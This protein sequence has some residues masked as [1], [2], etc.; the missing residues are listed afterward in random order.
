MRARYRV[1]PR[2]SFSLMQSRGQDTKY[3]LCGSRA[4][5]PMPSMRSLPAP[6][7]FILCRYSEDGIFMFGR[8]NFNRA[9]VM[10]L[11]CVRELAEH[12]EANDPVRAPP[13][14]IEVRARPPNSTKQRAAGA[15]PVRVW[16]TRA[17]VQPPSDPDK[18]SRGPDADTVGGLS[19]CFRAPLDEWP[20]AMKYLAVD[21]KWLLVY[22]A[23]R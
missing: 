19:V 4:L 8:S 7:H 2:G 23:K 9:L 15:A 11:T 1:I 14:R 3:R 16:L 6:T 21:V 17:A 18:S 20:R 5:V 22:F 10:L 12:V 13:H